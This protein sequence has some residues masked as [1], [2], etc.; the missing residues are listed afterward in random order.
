MAQTKIN[1]ADSDALALIYQ[2]MEVCFRCADTFFGHKFALATCNFK[3]KGKAAGMAYLQKNELRFNRF[4]Y[5][6]TPTVF[7]NTVIPHEVAHLVV[8]Q[9]YGLSV[10][11]HGK[12]WQAVMLKVY[13]LKPDRTHTFEVPPQKNVFGYR[14][15]CK[16][17][18]FSKHRHT[19][20]KKGVEYMCKNCRSSLQFTG[21]THSER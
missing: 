21:Y 20:A 18:L 10:K 2:K 9:I 5:E 19:K 1:E 6:Q 8:F 3:L 11:P 12:E 13:G 15:S 4:M 7:L 16:E 14:C 17:H